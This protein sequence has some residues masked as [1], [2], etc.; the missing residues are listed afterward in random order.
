MKPR[1]VHLKQS[2]ELLTDDPNLRWTPNALRKAAERIAEAQAQAAS[3]AVHG[4]LVVSG[5]G[6]VPGGRGANT[7]DLFGANSTVSKYSDVIGRRSTADNTIMLS[8]AL[9]DLN[10][11][12]IMLAGPHSGFEDVTLGIVQMYT[13]ELVEA[14]YAAG[15]VVLMAGGTGKDGQTTDAGVVEYAVWQAKAH[16]EMQSIAL[17]ATKFN[18]VYDSDPATNP[19]AK[20]YTQ[21]SA[22]TMLSDYE[23]FKAVDHR[24]LEVLEQAHEQQLDVQL[25]IYAAEYS[26]VDALR[27]PSLGTLVH[28][29]AVDSQLA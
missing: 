25:Q 1:I 11:P 15:K 17:K 14:A 20:R 5:G 22:A 24:C 18:G 27:D 19:D 10:V 8:A 2:G 12:H 6:N 7:R 9:T 26:I 13:P 16:P 29:Q 28:S 4:L 3:L 21:I 23:R